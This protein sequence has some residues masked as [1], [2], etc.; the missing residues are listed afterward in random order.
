MKQTQ[1]Q[2]ILEFLKGGRNIDPIMA[3]NHLGCFRL[4][5]RISD[6]RREGHNIQK[7]TVYNSDTGKHYASYYLVK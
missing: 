6:L 2:Q 5:S 1:N 7:D 4:A 3:L